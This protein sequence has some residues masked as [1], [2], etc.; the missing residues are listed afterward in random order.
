MVGLRDELVIRLGLLGLRLS[1]IRANLGV[2]LSRAMR[3]WLWRSV[4]TMS[5]HSA[6]EVVDP[7]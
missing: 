7:H 4:R 5:A 6:I 1:Q 2:G 3:R